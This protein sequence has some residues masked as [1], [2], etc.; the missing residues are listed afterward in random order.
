MNRTLSRGFTLIELL[1]VVSIIALLISIL[2]PSL[3]GARDQAKAVK[4]GANLAATG[5]AFAAYAAEFSGAFPVSYCYPNDAGGNCDV[6]NQPSNRDFGYV[7]WSW[8]LFSDGKVNDKSFQCPSFMKGGMPRTNPGP[9]AE[10]WNAGQIDDSGSMVPQPQSIEDKQATRM[11]YTTNAAIVPR[12]KFTPNLT[13]EAGLAGERL[14]DYVRE[15]E[16]KRAG[17]TILATEF[18]N[19]WRVMTLGTDTGGRLSKSHRPVS[20]LWNFD[21]AYVPFGANI[22]ADLNFFYGSVPSSGV[23]SMGLVPESQIDDASALSNGNYNRANFVGRHHPSRNSEKWGG[24]ANFL[25]VDSHV[26]SLTVYQTLQKR[27]WGER[28]YS[29]TGDNNEVVMFNPVYG[30]TPSRRWPD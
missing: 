5:R 10:N 6:Y 14:N 24:A 12:N 15:N 16:I 27:L 23:N 22:D 2:L 1:V 21:S 25:F 11:A 30:N 8:F 3:R 4:C 13:G 18:N 20:P 19:E 9:I 28:F 26:E 29:I 7:H 17:A